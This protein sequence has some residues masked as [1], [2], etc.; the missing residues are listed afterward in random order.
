MT[1]HQ[2]KKKEKLS[3]EPLDDIPKVDWET[4]E[5]SDVP[6]AKKELWCSS[7]AEAIRNDSLESFKAVLK[8]ILPVS[9]LIH[10]FQQNWNDDIADIDIIK[11]AVIRG[12]KPIVDCMIVVLGESKFHEFAR[13]GPYS[14]I[15]IAAIWGHVELVE[16][17]FQMLLLLV[18]FSSTLA[19][20]HLEISSSLL[21]FLKRWSILYCTSHTVDHQGQRRISNRCY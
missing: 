7:A 5:D 12:N 11:I 14:G 13:W 19:K 15:H 4:F 18:T 9:C 1:V 20:T 8:S 17:E 2:K 21:I 16:R 6:Q 3:P 10:L